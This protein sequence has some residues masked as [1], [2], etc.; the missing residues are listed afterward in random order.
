MDPITSFAILLSLAVASIVVFIGLPAY[1]GYKNR[2][3]LSK[4]RQEAQVN[5]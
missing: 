1:E 2:R 4:R 3:E 5:K